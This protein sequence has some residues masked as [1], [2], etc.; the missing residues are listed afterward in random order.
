MGKPEN[1]KD[2]V[3]SAKYRMSCVSS[4]VMAEVAVAMTEGALKYGRHN[5]RAAGVL[6]SVNKDAA[7]HH[8][9]A[10]WEG[11]DIDPDSGLHHIVKAIAALTVLRD[12]MLAKNWIDD[13]PPVLDPSFE[14]IER[15]NADTRRLMEK[16]PTPVPA[17][18][19]KQSVKDGS[20]DPFATEVKSYNTPKAPDRQKL[21]AACDAAGEAI[22]GA[23]WIY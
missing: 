4:A 14:W 1:P 7:K 16:Y 23:D 22:Q 5:Y 10:W 18:T 9:D 19:Q 8:V 12:G 21:E 2:R 15:C 17:F 13:R 11:Q 20:Y 3:G 6:A